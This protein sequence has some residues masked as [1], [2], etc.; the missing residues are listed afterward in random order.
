MQDMGRFANAERW[1]RGMMKRP[2]RTR[3]EIW[4]PSLTFND[5]GDLGSREV[6]IPYSDSAGKSR[7]MTGELAHSR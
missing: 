3:P 2:R 6:E 4:I 7:I 5:N 1:R